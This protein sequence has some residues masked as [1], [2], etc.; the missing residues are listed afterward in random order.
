M[1]FIFVYF[2]LL[3]DWGMARLSCSQYGTSSRYST[4]RAKK[5]YSLDVETTHC[6]ASTKHYAR[7]SSQTY[8]FF[9]QISS[10]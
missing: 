3:I 1:F 10:S 9:N 8:A 4:D 5:Y 2:V 6:Y 7:I